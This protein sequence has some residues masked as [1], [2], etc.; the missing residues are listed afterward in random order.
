MPM[1]R[2]SASSSRIHLVAAARKAQ[3][4]RRAAVRCQASTEE[5]K[6]DATTE[7]D[8]SR[9][10]MAGSNAARKS[11]HF[12]LLPRCTRVHGWAQ[13]CAVFRCH[14][15]WSLRSKIGAQWWSACPRKLPCCR[16]CLHG[17]EA[18]SLLAHVAPMIIVIMPLVVA[19]CACW[20]AVPFECART[21][22]GL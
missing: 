10:R 9:V 3:A 1:H 7:D 17:V 8:G 19:A 11:V 13:R 15:Q 21:R 20:A 18:C 22:R 2:S 4:K 12:T 6:T 16:L 14:E 5:E